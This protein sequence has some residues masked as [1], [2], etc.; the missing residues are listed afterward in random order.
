MKKLL[1]DKKKIHI[2]CL[3]KIESSK[4]L[5]FMVV[6]EQKYKTSE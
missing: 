4:N 3:R 1:T 2:L 6:Y 5:Y